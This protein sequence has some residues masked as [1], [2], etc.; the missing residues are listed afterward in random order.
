M[1]HYEVLDVRKEASSTDIRAAYKRRA[2]S[3]HPDK[4][5][6]SAE[7]QKVLDA[8]QTLSD[9]TRRRQYD[10]QQSRIHPAGIQ[11]GR[12]RPDVIVRK[13]AQLLQRMSAGCRRQT[14]LSR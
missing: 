12:R 1:S 11:C 10:Q 5:G 8:F 9:T 3:T 7:F 2:L 4:G 13:L 14:I 6:I